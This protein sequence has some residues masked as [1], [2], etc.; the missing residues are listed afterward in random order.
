VAAASRASPP[1]PDAG[2]G[3]SDDALPFPSSRAPPV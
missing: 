2:G 1:G 3:S